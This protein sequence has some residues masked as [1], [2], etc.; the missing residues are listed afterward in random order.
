[1]Y[2]LTVKKTI[3]LICFGRSSISNVSGMERVYVNMANAL[4]EKG[5]RVVALCNDDIGQKPFFPF[6]E[7]VIFINLGLG[8]IKA[9]IHKKILR[10][11]SKFLKLKL[12]NPVD[13]YKTHILSMHMKK[14][15]DIYNPDILICYESN[16]LYCSNYLNLS[17]AKIIMVH[18]SVH[19][20]FPKLTA[21][22]I[23][24]YN[25]ADICQVLSPSFVEIAKKYLK[26]P[27]RY[28]PNV[29]EQVSKLDMKK[30]RTRKKVIICV[31]RIE[32]K[33]KRQL[34]LIRS[35]AQ[36]A[37]KFSDWCIYL[38]GEEWDK[39]YVDEIKNYINSNRLEQHVFLKGTTKNILDVLKNA[40][41]FAFPSASEGFGLALAEG[42]SLGLPGIGYKDANG[43]KDLIIDGE[44]GFLC[45]DINDFTDKLKILIENENLRKKFGLKAHESMKR[46]SPEK[47]WMMW[48]ELIEEILLENTN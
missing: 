15:T 32:A 18:N 31:G 16:A 20:V 46:Y 6:N 29:V 5:Y 27:V 43:V 33:N 34:L 24:E 13:F 44:T 48:T 9:P 14:V 25:K 12:N 8:K 23:D 17:A 2:G 30:T 19:E 40:D 45:D 10:E 37:D 28:I 36:I 35:F 39:V 22:Q 7:K 41:I 1:M 42:L 4:S 38:Y 3:I 21:R 47:V 11:F 26:I